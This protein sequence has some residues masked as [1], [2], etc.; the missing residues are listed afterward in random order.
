VLDD[1]PEMYD[2]AES[3][4]LRPLLRDQPYNLSFVAGRD[5]R[6]IS[7]FH[8]QRVLLERIRHYEKEWTSADVRIS[9]GS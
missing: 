8:A 5:N 6:V 1:L 9:S 7:C 4:G 3:L 2:L